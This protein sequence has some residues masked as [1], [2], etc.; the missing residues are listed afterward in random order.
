M[1]ARHSG[2]HGDAEQRAG[3]LA[4]AKRFVAETCLVRSNLLSPSLGARPV[5]SPRP[6][7]TPRA[8]VLSRHAASTAAR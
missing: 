8:W 2:A 5:L 4:K 6:S 7:P 1:P 3:R